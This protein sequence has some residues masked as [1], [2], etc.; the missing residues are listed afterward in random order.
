MLLILSVI[1]IITVFIAGIIRY[2]STHPV[3]NSHGQGPENIRPD[4]TC[5]HP[6]TLNGHEIC[7][8]P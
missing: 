5:I 1:V 8:E 7:P 6:Q 3:L 4:G 2:R